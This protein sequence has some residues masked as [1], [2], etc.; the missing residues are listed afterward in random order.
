MGLSV[1]P[2]GSVIIGGFLVQFFGWASTFYFLIIYCFFLIYLTS[3]LPETGSPSKEHS[4]HPLQIIR[5]YAEV[6]KY[7]R[8]TVFSLAIAGVFGFFTFLQEPLLF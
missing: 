3:R 2:F 8:L 7:G 5:D 1:F 6:L 4:I